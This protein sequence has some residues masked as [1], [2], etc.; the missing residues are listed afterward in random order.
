MHGDFNI[1]DDLTFPSE[2]MT[3]SAPQQCSE[4]LR[5]KILL[6]PL[7]ANC[8]HC[9]QLRGFPE[10]NRDVNWRLILAASFATSITVISCI[11][12]GGKL[13]GSNLGISF[14]GP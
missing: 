11:H 6:Q 5:W 7:T 8:M 12:C 10:R 3:L 13:I 9:F 4:F 1:K 14:L 2:S